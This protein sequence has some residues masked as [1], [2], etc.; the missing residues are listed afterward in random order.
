MHPRKAASSSSSLSILHASGSGLFALGPR[1][2]RPVKNEKV[3]LEG[4]SEYAAIKRFPRSLLRVLLIA[5]DLRKNKETCY[6]RSCCA[7]DKCD[8]FEKLVAF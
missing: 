2:S 8:Y 1:R 5:V 4:S 6:S 7:G 3:A